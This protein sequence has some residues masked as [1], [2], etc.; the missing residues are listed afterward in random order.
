MRL[1][2]YKHIP[3]TLSLRKSKVLKL[4]KMRS[5]ARLLNPSS[6]PVC[7]QHSIAALDC[8]TPHSTFDQW[9]GIPEK[10]ERSTPVHL[11]TFFQQL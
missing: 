3:K 8:A 11:L 7:C 5:E 6:L 9:G 4:T 10:L 2:L 1:E